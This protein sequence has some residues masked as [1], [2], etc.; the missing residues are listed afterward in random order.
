MQDDGAHLPDALR[1][2]DNLQGGVQRPAPWATAPNGSEPK[3]GSSGG[4][5]RRSS[6][7]NS[8]DGR[9]TSSS[10]GDDLQENVARLLAS[11]ETPEPP[12]RAVSRRTRW[13]VAGEAAAT[14]AAG[15][16][17][18]RTPPSAGV[19][20]SAAA[21]ANVCTPP[22]SQASSLGGGDARSAAPWSAGSGGGGCSFLSQP[23]DS[24]LAA[25]ITDRRLKT[26][27]VE[28]QALLEVCCAVLAVLCR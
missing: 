8:Y 25:A 24:A 3:R 22:G 4:R 17:T 11:L 26:A 27:L 21:G 15:T 6:G 18:A 13:A 5:A 20:A 28:K 19:E 16:E 9:P 12:R 10:S 2:I 23:S 1:E 7:S 14:A